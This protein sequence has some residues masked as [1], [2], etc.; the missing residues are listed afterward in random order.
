MKLCIISACEVVKLILVQRGR[1]WKKFGEL[2]LFALLLKTARSPVQVKL[3]HEGSASPHRLGTGNVRSWSNLLR[4]A[5]L[6]L[7][8]SN[9]DL[10]AII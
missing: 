7:A 2:I 9:L 5:A 6:L 4:S 3:S 1:T 10:G 8:P